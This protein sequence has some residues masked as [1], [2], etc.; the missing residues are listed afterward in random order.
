MTAVLSS[1]PGQLESLVG[2]L[3]GIPLLA[4][5]LCKGQPEIWDE[6]SPASRDPDP[7]DTAGRLKFALNAC[8]RCPAL[9]ACTQWVTS[10]RPSKRPVG[11]VAGELWRAGQ[12]CDT[13]ED[14]Q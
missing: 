7:S 13:G 5:A 6:P 1:R 9:A 2:A 4:G 12:A 3:G 14:G 11:V 8:Q 10:L